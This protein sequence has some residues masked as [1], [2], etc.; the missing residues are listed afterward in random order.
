[1][2]GS[3]YCLDND[4]ILKLST[5]G[6]FEKTL[7][8]FGVEINQ[9]KILETFQYKSKK[10]GQ[11]KRKRNPVKYNLEDALSVAETCDKISI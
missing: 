3:V 4:I 10:Q 11:Q 8:T 1:M 2:I 5:Y 9:V 7:N 6:L